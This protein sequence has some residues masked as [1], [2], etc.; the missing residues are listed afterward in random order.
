MPY[1]PASG[2]IG[3]RT[4]FWRTTDDE[5]PDGLTVDA[6]DHVVCAVWN[7]GCVVR[8]NAAGAVV[9]RVGLPAQRLTSVAFGGSGMDALYVTSA[10]QDG[11]GAAGDEAAGAVF[12]LTGVGRGRPERPSRLVD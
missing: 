12:R 3:P 2:V 7:G 4:A 10:L 9:D 6:G 11:P 8:L 1:D 5:L